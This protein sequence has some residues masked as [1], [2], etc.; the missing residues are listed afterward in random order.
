MGIYFPPNSSPNII[1]GFPSLNKSVRSDF[2][3]AKSKHVTDIS[4][5]RSI[6]SSLGNVQRQCPEGNRDAK[7][8]HSSL[9][10]PIIPYKYPE[11]N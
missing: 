10:V 9:E 8:V 2:I 4:K 11:V 1:L 3:P 6:G 7:R 5:F